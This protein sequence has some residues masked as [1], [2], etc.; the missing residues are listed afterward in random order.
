MKKIEYGFTNRKNKKLC[1]CKKNWNCAEK[2][3]VAAKRQLITIKFQCIIL[4][5]KIRN[6]FY[7]SN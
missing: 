1:F 5:M 3:L 7:A 6:A 4:S 2:S